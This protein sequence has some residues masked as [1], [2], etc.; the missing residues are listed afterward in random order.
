M[1][2]F[3]TPGQNK[4]RPTALVLA[5][6]RRGAEDPVAKLQNKSHKCFVEIDGEVM[7]ERVI[8]VL[9]DAGIFHQI[10]VSIESADWLG[11]S[12]R[13]QQW[14]DEGAIQ[15]SVSAGTLTDSVFN[16]VNQ[17][18]TP[19]P[20]MITTGDNALHTAELIKGF[21]ETVQSSDAEILIGVTE[22]KL[23]KSVYPDSPL[24]FHRFREGAY[25]NC[26]L[27][28]I[29]SSAGLSLAEV[30]RGGGQFGKKHMRVIKALGL[31]TFIVYRFRL[32]TMKDFLAH[33]GRRFGT[34]AEPGLI[35]YAF[36]PIDVDNRASFLLTEEILKK[37]R[38]AKRK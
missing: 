9:L 35:A 2:E 31:W 1:N 13:L 16:A 10:L 12:S 29:R 4:P 18:D 23:V 5:A 21:W 28:F 38:T 33:I 32:K 26:N 15:F 25:S 24:A 37:R 3:K 36:A 8:A 20:L 19:F 17:A 7:L 6:S 14:L 27:Y 11:S 22:E 30:F 34:T